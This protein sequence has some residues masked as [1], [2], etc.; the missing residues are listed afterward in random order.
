M[1]K[2][3]NEAMKFITP[4]FTLKIFNHCYEELKNYR[5]IDNNQNVDDFV[6]QEISS[7]DS[8]SDSS[9]DD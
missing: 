3:L 7:D 4:E 9:S 1:K 5:K 6:E 2:Q 8:N